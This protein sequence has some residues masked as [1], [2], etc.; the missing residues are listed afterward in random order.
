MSDIKKFG[1][2]TGELFTLTGS[3]YVGYYN[4]KDNVAYTGKY[5]QQIPLGYHFVN[6]N[7]SGIV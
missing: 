3:N 7:K 5:N 2:A 6:K 4:I 1:Y